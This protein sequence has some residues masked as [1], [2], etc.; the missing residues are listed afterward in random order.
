MKKIVFQDYKELSIET[1]KLIARIIAG[2]PDALL[3]F[4]AGETSLGTYAALIQMHKNGIISF[5]KCKVVGLDE[6]VHLDEMQN[7]NCYHFLK[8]HL[9]DHI[10]MNPENLCFFNG[11]SNDLQKE[12]LLTDQFI[13]ANGGIDMMLLGVGMNG[14]LGLNEPG[15]SFDNYSHIVE[16]DSVTKRVGQKYFSA[17]AELTKGITLGMKHIFETKTVILQISGK[18]KSPVVKRLL[19]AE[20]STELPSSLLKKHPNTFLLLDADAASKEE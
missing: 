3:C 9:F 18:K 16:L 5:N 6:W 7:E 19:E 11:E 1:A 17:R 15:I 14:H 8:K 2:K 13:K 10:D 12:C 20:V 4:P